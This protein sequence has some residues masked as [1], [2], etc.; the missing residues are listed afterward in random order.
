MIHTDTQTAFF[1][2]H[3]EAQQVNNLIVTHHLLLKLC[4]S[5]WHHSL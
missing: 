4:C 3:D 5:D 1:H 2:R